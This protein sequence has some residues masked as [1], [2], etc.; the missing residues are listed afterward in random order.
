VKR[1]KS[2]IIWVCSDC[3]KKYGYVAT[4]CSTFH[5]DTC[6]VCGEEKPC[7]EPRDYGYLPKL[8]STYEYKGSKTNN[9]GSD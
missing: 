5:V 2:D 3:G 6:D 1:N 8:R 9:K 7:T 4:G